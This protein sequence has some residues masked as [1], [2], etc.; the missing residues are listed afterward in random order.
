[1]NANRKTA[2]VIGGLIA[3]AAALGAVVFALSGSQ[4]VTWFVLIGIPLIVVVGIMLY[5][6]GVIAQSGTSEE[7]FVRTR[8]RSVAEEYQAVLRQRN[9][10]RT[11]YPDWEP[12]IDAQLESIGGDFETQGVSF[13]L[14]TGAFDLGAVGSADIQE[15]ERLSGEIERVDDS[16]E[17]TFQEF[18]NTE[19]SRMERAL[20]RLEEVDLIQ[21][22]ETFD[23]LNGTEEVP[24]C[25]D[26]LDGARE[27]TTASVETA[28]ETVRE[29]GRGEARATDVDAINRE[30]DTALE[31]VDQ[32]DFESATESVLEARDQLRDQFSGSFEESRD[33]MLRLIER[34]EQANIE[35]AVDA[36]AMED[37]R[38]IKS[39]V[40]EIDSALD[41]AE[42]SQL[43]AELREI[44]VGMIEAMQQEIE[45]N[46]RKLRGAELPSGYYTEPAVV[47][48]EFTDSFSNIDDLD[49]FADRWSD[50]AVELRDA[51]ETTE[52]KA[53]VV[54]AYD[55]VAERIDQLL[56]RQGEV[57]GEDLPMRHPDQFLG[58]YFRQNEGVEFDPDVPMLRRG[59]VETYGV[60][61][62]VT[63]EH[64]SETPRTATLELEGGGYNET[65]TVET[66][67]AGTASF[68]SVPA[69]THTL[70][71]APGDDAFGR[72][73]RELRV[74]DDSTV[75]IEFTERALRDQLCS[76]IDVDIESVLPEM[77]PRLESLFEQEGYVSSEMQLPVQ[78]SFAPCLLAA[79]GEQTDRGLCRDGEEVIVYDHSQLTQE[80]TNVLRYNVETGDQLRFDELRRNFLSAPVPDSVI[81]DVIGTIDGEHSVTTA[82]TGIKIQ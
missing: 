46:A 47:G 70:S 33:S 68:E 25:R 51:H 67:V 24:K 65:A 21:S 74:D 32:Y 66:R 12:Q 79:W 49:A 38:R 71:A 35:T 4:G 26:R 53:A 10:L 29:M 34:V 59:D 44:C 64:G 81:R 31:A 60:A 63:Y 50:V 22:A 16:V 77:R 14:E 5:V 13:D 42:L 82:Q 1:M 76:D 41:L 30:L 75:A 48:E 2:L 45:A 11:G 15:F 18:V 40:N 80:L 27:Q 9:E 72:I 3:I 61:V 37:L 17:S 52:S 69:G 55:D 54:D 19:L 58:L 73:E 57:T 23:Q 62:D 56:N 28:V 36:A 8:A 7:Q 78:A 39:T 43:R 6:R 20:S